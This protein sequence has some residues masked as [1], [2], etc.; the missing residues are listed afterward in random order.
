MYK[1]CKT[2]QSAARQRVLEQGLLAAM[3]EHRYEEISILD[4]CDRLQIPRKSFYRYFSGKDGALHALIDHTLMELEWPYFLRDRQSYRQELG[5]FFRFWK[6]K[7]PFLDA[8]THSG[9]E[10]LLIRRTVEQALQERGVSLEIRGVALPAGEYEL[11]FGI[12]GLMS[13]VLT[14]HRRGCVTSPEQMARLVMKLISEPL[15]MDQI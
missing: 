14:W 2:E 7:K 6:G 1:L 9:L 3:A 13:V 8:I 4:L 10:D 15:L 12:S 11:I 5:R